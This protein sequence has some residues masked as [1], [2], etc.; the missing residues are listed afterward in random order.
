MRLNHGPRLDLSHHLPDLAD[1]KEVVS[2]LCLL[3]IATLGHLIYLPFY[4]E[5]VN[6]FYSS[7]QNLFSVTRHKAEHILRYL[8]KNVI[9]RKD[10]VEVEFRVL[11]QTYLVQQVR[12]L[13]RQCSTRKPVDSSIVQGEKPFFEKLA[14]A[15]AASF[16]D[17][18]WFVKE[19]MRQRKLG[20]PNTSYA[21]IS[22]EAFVTSVRNAHSE[23]V[24]SFTDIIAFLII[25][26]QIFRKGAPS[27]TLNFLPTWPT[28]IKIRRCA[29]CLTF[30]RNLNVES[31]SSSL[32]DD[33]RPFIFYQINFA[34]LSRY[35]PPNGLGKWTN[36]STIQAF[37]ILFLSYADC[38]FSISLD[39]NR[40]TAL[41]E[42]NETL[43]NL[44]SVTTWHFP[45]LAQLAFLL[46]TRTPSRPRVFF[47][48]F[49]Y[50]H[51]IPMSESPDPSPCIRGSCCI[52]LHCARN[53]SSL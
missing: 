21:W 26:L 40:I 4:E 30:Y 45:N 42:W 16:Y 38:P 44:E 29:A 46:Q 27:S 53:S 15:V 18:K 19:M 35:L 5:V 48:F 51:L 49:E 37:A 8:D 28:I 43:R 12:S 34:A 13:I 47:F 10:G 32:A 23:R 20:Y 52:S 36:R 31:S 33:Q 22:N 3:N 11:F 2:L 25:L 7:H 1:F 50:L 6:L 41:S 14:E 9:F 39:L 17:K 24:C